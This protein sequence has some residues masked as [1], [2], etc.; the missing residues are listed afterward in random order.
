GIAND[1]PTA[2][3]AAATLAPEIVLLDIG[4]PHMDGYEVARRLRQIP[5]L[6]PPVLIAVSGYGQA[7]DRRRSHEAGFDDHVLKPVAA[8]TLQDLLARHGPSR[9]GARDSTRTALGTL[10]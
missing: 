2:I 10:D 3:E 7:E 4:M 9:S 1:G 6:A 8:D 5:N